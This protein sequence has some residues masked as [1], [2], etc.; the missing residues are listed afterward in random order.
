MKLLNIHQLSEMLNVKPKTIYHWTHIG[1][2]PY[3]KLG[4]LLRFDQAD[5]ERWLKIQKQ[6]SIRK[7]LQ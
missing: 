2:I 7:D 4:G 1:K 5:I 6:R 3:V